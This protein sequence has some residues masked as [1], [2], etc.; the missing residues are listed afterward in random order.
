VTDVAVT[1]S[2]QTLY[3]CIIGIF[4]AIS[5]GSVWLV[6]VFVRSRHAFF[7]RPFHSGVCFYIASFAPYALLKAVAVG[8]LLEAKTQ[9]QQLSA[10]VM[11]N[12]SFMM[13]FW[14]G[15]AGTMALIQ[16]WMHL[17]SRH[18]VGKSE[19]VML[20]T[21]HRTWRLMRV[22]VVVVCVLYGV[23]FLSLVGV[24]GQASSACAAAADSTVCIAL[25]SS[26]TPAACQ[27]VVSLAQ[28]IVY[29][30]G[31]F[32]AVVVV[33]FTFY[34]LMF[35]GLV[36]AMLTS[37]ATFSNLTKLQRMLISNP[38]LRRIMRPY[39][40]ARSPAAVVVM[41]VSR[42]TSG[43]FPPRGGRHRSRRRATWSSGARA[44]A[45]SA[46]SSPSSACAA[47]RAR[48]C[49]WRCSSLA[50]YPTAACIS[51]RRRCWWRRCPPCSPSLC[52]FDT[53]AAALELQEA[54][55]LACR[56]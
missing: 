29:Y 43:S 40:L 56:C 11:L 46:S 23:G 38:F 21:V 25:T 17:I 37:D 16:L 51:A 22:T 27:R 9:E 28:G 42:H 30:E 41:H 48:L 55:T 36:Y 1:S 6:V 26:A 31:A 18:T 10:G 35:N 3:K 12:S 19:P 5:L 53:T 49:W 44:C 15:F 4:A 14:L 20:G 52:S 54:A 50:F 13:F 45:R 8:R 2:E 34:A 47:S 7:V 24:Y 39:A 33:V 32:A